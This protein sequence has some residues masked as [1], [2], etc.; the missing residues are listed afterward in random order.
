LA[1]QTGSAAQRSSR[2]DQGHKVVLHARSAER[3]ATVGML[4]DRCSGTVI[5]DLRSAA[6]IRVMLLRIRFAVAAPEN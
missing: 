3:A 5:G 1:V 2:F 4:G 6:S